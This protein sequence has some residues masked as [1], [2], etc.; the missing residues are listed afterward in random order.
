MCRAV[1]PDRTARGRQHLEPA[2]A[3]G[4]VA[5]D[6]DD[7]IRFA[8]PL[9]ARAVYSR[10]TPA[11]RADVHRWFSERVLDPDEQTLHAD[12]A[13]S[14]RDAGLAMR[15][16]EAAER[17]RRKGA[18]EFASRARGASRGADAV[19]NIELELCDAFARP[20]ITS[21]PATSYGR[22]RLRK[23]SRGDTR[24]HATRA[25]A[26]ACR[27]DRIRQSFPTAIELL[28]DAIRQPGAERGSVA[29][30]EAISASRN[31]R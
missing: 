23:R 8:H 11:R 12:L 19:R 14:D 15:L 6:A 29:Q 22:P 18:P 30:L 3:A 31:S 16:H 1:P 4:L 25:C 24:S 26:L 7:R 28:E 5:L 17:A 9:F 20:S 2:I 21:V 13:T 27:P 10:A